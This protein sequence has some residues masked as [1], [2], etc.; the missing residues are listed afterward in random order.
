[1]KFY[2]ETKPLY[3]ETGTP[4][5]GLGVSLLQARNGTNC[6][7]DT[8]QNNNMLKPIAFASKKPIQQ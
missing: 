5:I 8:A 4:G 6:Q 7:R 3:L 1:M 2:N